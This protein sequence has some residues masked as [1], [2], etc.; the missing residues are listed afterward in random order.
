MIVPVLRSRR[1][2]GSCKS[3]RF[4]IVDLADVAFA[5][6]HAPSR[7]PRTRAHQK[8]GS[9][10]SRRLTKVNAAPE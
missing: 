3:E 1:L 7:E 9:H 10:L 6:P 2:F 4:S 8:G 5:D